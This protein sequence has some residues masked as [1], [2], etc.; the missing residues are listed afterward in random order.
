MQLI[1]LS[2]YTCQI[3]KDNLMKPNVQIIILKWFNCWTIKF[4]KSN[5]KVVKRSEY[6]DDLGHNA[7]EYWREI[8]WN[9]H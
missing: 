5:V 7:E 4:G 6:M 1:I 9:Q 2:N 3:C 8:G